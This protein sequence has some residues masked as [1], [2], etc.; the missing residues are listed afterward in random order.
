MASQFFHINFSFDIAEAELAAFKAWFAHKNFLGEKE[1][2]TE[3]K[4][5]LQM[6]ALLAST[7][8]I[9]APDLIRFELTMLGLF[10]T[11]LVIGNSATRKFVLVEFEDAKANSIFQRGTNQYRHWARRL[12]HGIGQVVDWAWLRADNPSAVVL[13]EAFGGEIRYNA[14]VVVCGRDSSIAEGTERRRFEFRR[15]RMMIEGFPIQILTYDGM[16]EAMEQQLQVGRTF[17]QP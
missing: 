11:D 17:A 10:R 8:A 16:I 1:I 12:E 3:L 5:R 4:S 14:Y 13:T 6:C 7:G 2:M 15:H 9:P